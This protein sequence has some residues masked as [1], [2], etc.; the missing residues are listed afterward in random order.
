VVR[1][2]ELAAWRARRTRLLAL[3]GGAVALLLCAHLLPRAAGQALDAGTALALGWSVA[4]GS[5]VAP[6]ARS[7]AVGAADLALAVLAA[8]LLA[9]M[10][11]LGRRRFLAAALLLVPLALV[12]PLLRPPAGDEVYHL[13]LLESLRE[14]RP[15]VA[16]TR[17]CPARGGEPATAQPDPLPAIALVT[18]PGFPARPRCPGDRGP[19]GRRRPAARRP[20]PRLAGEPHAAWLL[21]RH[22]PG[23]DLRHP[24]VAGRLGDPARGV[25]TGSRPVGRR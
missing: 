17:S 12:Q 4:A 15:A 22:L 6:L 20:R 9:M 11:A 24:A 1:A 3:L 5:A 16:T 13:Q 10:P 8:A 14:T 18:L 7:A 25:G 21:I 23:A 19:G 2:E